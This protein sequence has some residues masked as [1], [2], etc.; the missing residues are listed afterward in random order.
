M[1]CL[2][3]YVCC[4]ALWLSTTIPGH[5]DRMALQV[6][7]WWDPANE[8]YR[9]WLDWVEHEFEKS[10]PD[11]D[12]QYVFHSWSNYLE[13]FA[14]SL[15]EGNPP[16]VLP[17][18]VA[19]GR[20]LYEQ[21]VLQNLSGYISKSPDQH[22]RNF[23][24]VARYY[25]A[26]AAAQFGIPFVFDATSLTYNRAALR[27]A[28]FSED[29]PGSLKKWDE[30]ISMAKR[31]TRRNGEQIIRSGYAFWMGL[32]VF[33]SWL[34]ANGTSLFPIDHS[35]TNF[36]TKAAR[37][38]LVFLRDLANTH[39]VFSTEAADFT[40]GKSAINSLGTWSGFSIER[41]APDLA[42]S[43]TAFPPGPLS[44]SQGTVGWTSMLAIPK[45]ISNT[46]AAWRYVAFC[47]GAKAQTQLA[48]LQARATPARLDYYR[49]TQYA[50]LRNTHQ[51]MRF[52]PQVAADMKPVVFYHSIEV[53]LAANR[54]F[55]DYMAGNSSADETLRQLDAE[56]NTI[57]KR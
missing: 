10:N 19:W 17:L 45:F 51:W 30:F 48:L 40:S 49:S 6:W 33:S 15:A 8:Q 25:V 13:R 22:L 23:V 36:T 1:K 47:T 4:C 39:Q 5:A 54:L 56:A 26:A 53:N 12:V 46:D 32:E 27:E 41:D 34:A 20:E 11:I 52:L 55:A 31:L 57:W 44:K 42:F 37:D 29:A 3:T 14:A 50:Q 38:T 28:G 24:P 16:D 21:G 18:P 35:V 2:L 7:N 43:M 9:A